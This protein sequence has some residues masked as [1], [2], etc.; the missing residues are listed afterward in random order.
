MKLLKELFS[1]IEESSISVSRADAAKV[2]HRDYLKTKH[3]KYRKYN[4]RKHKNNK[5]IT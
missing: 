4:P 3:K 2:Y 1:L 5:E